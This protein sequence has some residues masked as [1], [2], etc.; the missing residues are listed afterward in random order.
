MAGVLAGMEWVIQHLITIKWIVTFP[1]DAPFIPLDCVDKMIKKADKSTADIVCVASNNR[2]HPVCAL[3]SVALASDLRK[4]I[5]QDGVRKIDLWTQ[6]Y[7]LSTVNFS[8]EPF[9]PF[10]NINKPEDLKTAQE[11]LQV[12]WPKS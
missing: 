4:S 12:N 3:W 7:N 5:L 1:S 11:I 2:S 6:R 10:F 8:A 9:D